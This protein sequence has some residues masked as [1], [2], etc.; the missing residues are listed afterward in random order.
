MD[1]PEELKDQTNMVTQTMANIKLNDFKDVNNSWNT[2][3]C[4]I[5]TSTLT[6]GVSY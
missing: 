3:D 2:A 6:A 5:Y 1:K 4:L